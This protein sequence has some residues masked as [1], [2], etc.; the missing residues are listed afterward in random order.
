MWIL[1]FSQG[2]LGL[3]FNT[4]GLDCVAVPRF[5]TGYLSLCW[6]YFQ[7]P[8]GMIVRDSDQLCAGW[9]AARGVPIPIQLGSRFTNELFVEATNKEI[10]HVTGIL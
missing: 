10:Q 9:E 4:S 3:Q 2:C 6:A 5:K 8:S 7:N 1:Q